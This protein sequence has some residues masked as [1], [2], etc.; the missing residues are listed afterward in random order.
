MI[1][2]KNWEYFQH[3]KDRRPPW[4]KLYRGILDDPDWHALDGNSAKRLIMLWLIAS[5]NEGYLPDN[6]KIAFR[7]R[8]SESTVPQLLNRL[9]Q[10]LIQDDINVIST[11]YQDDTP[12]TETEAEAETETEAEAEQRP[13]ASKDNTKPKETFQEYVDAKLKP[14]FPEL[15]VED[16]LEKCEAYFSEQRR[17]VKSWKHTF[18]NWLE[19][20]REIQQKKRAQQPSQELKRW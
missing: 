3:F 10:W 14:R 5:E 8:I 12:E 4:I 16:E 19:K 2:I 7:L 13:T 9:E 20:A 15:D 18:R 11:R 17:Q 6:R 1:R